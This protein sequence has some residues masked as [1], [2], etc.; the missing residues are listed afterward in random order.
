MGEGSKKENQKNNNKNL[1]KQYNWFLQNFLTKIQHSSDEFFSDIFSFKLVSISKNINT[2]FQGNNYFVTKVRIDKK[3]NVFLRCSESTI[4]LIL[5]EILGES[6]TEFNLETISDLEARIITAFNDYVYEN[7][8]PFIRIT[9]ITSQT[10]N[11]DVVNI[12]CFVKSENSPYAE[13]GKFIISIPEVLLNPEDVVTTSEK[14][15]DEDF[16]SSKIEV[17]LRLGTTKFKVKELKQLEK[18][19]LV[20]FEKSK[21]NYMKLIFKDYER[22]FR[23]IPNPGLIIGID[24]NN[25]GGNN[26]MADNSSQNLWDDI[27]VEM[28]AEFDKVKISLGELKTIEQ[29]L[30]LDLSS[31]YNN[32]ISL[33]VEDKIIARGEL[34]IINDRYGVRIEEVFATEQANNQV[35]QGVTPDVQPT[36]QQAP[37]QD[38]QP[39]PEATEEQPAEGENGEEFDY[40]DF[41]LED[42]DI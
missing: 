16:Y 2:L 17:N 22:G 35:P 29:G 23:V 34:V 8:A 37:T 3:N 12:T 25:S 41:E 36:E 7:I 27:E 38:V 42:E 6:K 39:T 19:D 32:K 4:E 26:N 24:D 20:I 1:F 11:I 15:K 5:N 10:K 40:S 9:P 30:V 28:G 21:A 14:F 18:D 33:K 31:V 13:S